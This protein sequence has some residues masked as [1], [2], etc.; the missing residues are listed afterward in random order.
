MLSDEIDLAAIAE[1]LS[2]SPDHRVLRRLTPRSEFAT[3]DGQATKV[4]I[5]FDVETTGLNTALDEVIELA[6]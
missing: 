3:C 5:L 4:G 2:K 6:M 1:T